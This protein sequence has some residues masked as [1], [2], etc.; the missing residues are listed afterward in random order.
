MES[1]VM[2]LASALL[3][4]EDAHQ[5]RGLSDAQN[6]EWFNLVLQLLRRISPQPELRKDLR[7]SAS[8]SVALRIGDTP[9]TGRLLDISRTGVGVEVE[10]ADVAMGADVTLETIEMGERTIDV[11][12]RAQVSRL[13]GAVV[14]VELAEDADGAKKAIFDDL[15]YPLYI[16]HLRSLCRS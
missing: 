7:F 15:Y 6:R 14:G 2:D 9:V 3:E 13:D 10:G 16:E 12:A 4:L 1:E 5:N 8:G 11:G